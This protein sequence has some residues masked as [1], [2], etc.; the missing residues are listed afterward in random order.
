MGEL[1][2]GG[3]LYVMV[4]AVIIFLLVFGEG[5]ITFLFSVLFAPF[6]CCVRWGLSFL[7]RAEC[8]VC[9]FFLHLFIKETFYLFY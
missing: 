4:T 8:W 6:G 3:A 1:A 7:N 5:G 9:C 2:F